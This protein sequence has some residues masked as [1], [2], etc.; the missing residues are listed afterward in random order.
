LQPKFEEF[1]KESDE[2]LRNLDTL[3]RRET[4]LSGNQG[5]DIVF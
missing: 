5:V 2:T 4:M 3:G 1:A